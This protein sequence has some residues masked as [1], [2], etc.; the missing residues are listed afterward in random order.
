VNHN[1]ETGPAMNGEDP[2]RVGSRVC[3]LSDLSIR[4]LRRNRALA[5]GGIDHAN[6]VKSF[7]PLVYG[8]V[9]LMIPEPEVALDGVVNA[10]FQAFALRWRRLRRRTLVASWLLRTTWFAATRERKRLR[11]PAPSPRTADAAGPL[12]LKTL[13]RLRVN[14]LEVL[15][16]HYVL[17]GSSN[18]CNR[19]SSRKEARRLKLARKSRASLD[20]RLRKQGAVSDVDELIRRLFTEAPQELEDHV[21]SRMHEWSPKQRKDPLVR[22]ALSAWQW[23][24]L[25][26]SLA[27]MVKGAAVSIFILALTI[28]LF[29]WLLRQGYLTFRLLKFVNQRV[30]KE[31]PELA[32]PARPWPAQV[33]ALPEAF[34]TTPTNVAQLYGLTNVWTS[35]LSFTDNQWQGIQPAPVKPVSRMMMDDGQI[36]LRN[37]NARRN[38]LAGV[39]GIEFNWQQ[40][41]LEFAGRTF[42]KVAVRYRGN[43]TFV[44]SLFGP[45]Q[46]FKVDLNKY[47]K[48]QNLAGA[49]TLNFVNAIPDNSYLHDALGEQLFRELGTVAPRT[50]FAYLTVDVPGKFD[51]QPLGL[52]VLVENIDANFAADR[53]GSRKVP[54]FKPVT[55]DLFKFLGNDWKVYAAMYDLKTQATDKQIARVIEF[56]RL[57]TSA[58]DAEFARRLPEFL[59]LEEFAAFLAG[60]VLLASYDGFLTNGQNYYFYLNPRDNRFGFVPW[61]QDHGWGEF[62]YVA[63]A[64]QREQASIWQPCSYNNRFVER[65]LK[66]EAFRAIYRRVLE[67]AMDELFTVDRLY[68][69]VDHV[70]AVIRPAVEAESSFRLKRFDLA[71]STNWINGP[72]DAGEREG[73]KAPVHQ[74]K[75]FIANRV[76]S[77]RDQ[78]DGK[79]QGIALHH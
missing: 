39:I 34:Q 76:K 11:L 79:A 30:I 72:R 31:I 53:F 44:N 43:G 77:V 70:A 10:V 61:D 23:F 41:Q 56:A 49:S 71:V 67:R 13:C 51:H 38:G 60:H 25:R 2:A 9:R 29:I 37:P 54:I 45:K 74:I 73:P 58:D 40:A 5:P 36:A 19:Q 21:L 16:L 27:R 7:L 42:G 62:G 47:V 64:D 59:D 33:V 32:Q 66:V 6:L 57:V 28:T 50:A 8:S 75:R 68:R 17:P 52:Y 22:A 20:K 14:C 4:D 26:R 35:K 48:G 24:E 65:V 69:Q 55:R 63:T 1:L 78:L 3:P 18:D 15:I 46:S 12:L